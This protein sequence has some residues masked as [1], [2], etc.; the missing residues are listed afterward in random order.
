[1]CPRVPPDILAAMLGKRY[2][3]AAISIRLGAACSM[4]IR[5]RMASRRA[6]MHSAARA[7]N[8]TRTVLADGTA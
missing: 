4:R 5:D 3:H 8:R 1:M 6:W 7:R 2:E